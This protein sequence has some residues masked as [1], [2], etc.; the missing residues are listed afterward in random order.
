MFLG[1]AGVVF[2]KQLYKCVSLVT[3]LLQQALMA[4][5]PERPDEYTGRA[6]AQRKSSFVGCLQSGV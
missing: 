4:P 2:G 3:Q 5:V 1:G 6:G